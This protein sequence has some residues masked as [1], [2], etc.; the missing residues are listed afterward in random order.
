M[1]TVDPASPTPPFDQLR[2]QIAA[3]IGDGRL[4]GGARLPTVRQ[5][6]GDL[7]LAANTVARAYRELEQAGLVHTR[8]RH[9]TF[10]VP[11]RDRVERRVQ[12]LAEDYAAHTRQLGVDAATALHQ[13]RAALGLLP[14]T[15]DDRP[16]HRDTDASRGGSTDQR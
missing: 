8:G 2:S 10:V 3:M 11:G 13:V 7:G 12:Q 14:V 6:A 9:G 1:F 16:P 4:P 15:G 5:L